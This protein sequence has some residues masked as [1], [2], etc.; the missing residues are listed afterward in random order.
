MIIFVFSAV[1]LK[2]YV[3]VALEALFC[4][5]MLSIVKYPRVKLLD[6]FCFSSD[7]AQCHMALEIIL[8][9]LPCM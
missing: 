9:L 3:S 1:I 4:L 8:V 2:V 5:K 6:K 7:T